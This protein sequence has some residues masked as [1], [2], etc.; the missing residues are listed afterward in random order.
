MGVLRAKNVG[1]DDEDGY[2]EEEEY[3]DEDEEETPGMSDEDREQLQTGTLKVKEGLFGSDVTVTDAQIQEALWHYYYDVG[4]SV[5]YLKNK[6]GT[7]LEEKAVTTPKKQ[8]TPSR[9]DQVV[10]AIPATPKS[11]TGRDPSF[12][13]LYL[14]ESS[15]CTAPR[16]NMYI[17]HLVYPLADLT[18]YMPAS[19]SPGFFWDT[20]WFGVPSHRLGEI[21]IEP[22]L[23][24]GRLLGGSSKPSKLAALAAA[25]KKKQ[26]DAKNATPA[27]NVETDKAVTL[28]DKLTLKSRENGPQTPRGASSEE[29]PAP[30]KY[31]RKRSPSPIQVPKR[32]A[33]PPPEPAKPLITFPDL[34]AQPSA[35]AAVLCGLDSPCHES[36]ETVNS[37]PL[38]YTALPDF[39]DA[40]PF[41]GPSPDDILSVTIGP[42]PKPARRT[43]DGHDLTTSMEKTVIEE[44]TKVRSKNLNVVVEF[45]RS[46]LK[47]MANFVVIGHVDHGKSTLMGRLLF[48]M[49]VISQRSIDK[50]RKEAE[51]MGKS[52]F[53]LAW[54]MDQ[55]SEERS[56]GVTVDIATD[57]F[58]TDTTQFTILDAPGH[59][60]FIPN[61]IA[62]ASQADFAVL[63]IDAST[64]SFESGLKGQTRE[65]AM[66]V[67]SMGVLRII[68]AVNKMDTVA[69]SQHRFEEI[70]RQMLAFLT[71]ASFSPKRITFV[72]CAGLTGEN[73]TRKADD[74]NAKWYTGE[75]LIEALDASEL[76]KRDLEKPFRLTIGDVFRGG[77]TTPVSISGRI[78]VGTVQVGDNILCM[79][80][81]ETATVKGIEVKDCPVDWAVAGQISTLHLVDIDPVHLRLGD[82]VTPISSPIKLYKSF[83]AKLLAFDHV[84]PSPVDVYRGRLQAEGTVVRL[85]ALLN[86]F[87]GE[88]VKKHPRIV[89]PGEVARVRVRLEREL[90]LEVG[91]RV[92][93]RFRGETVGA[94][95]VEG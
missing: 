67:R 91:G 9:F 75:T 43:S 39:K 80:A 27:T 16:L 81:R 61:M 65:H 12:L 52:S 22:R 18:N 69:W 66:I 31:L 47:R 63:V 25:R 95:V 20:P 87:S 76:P 60:D 84:I 32:V 85:D 23:P 38:P 29:T 3:Y 6:Y 62:G 55:T 17:G 78:D 41:A 86:R 92:V 26:E 64:N 10:E 7:A 46:G 34:R 42:K 44:S 19:P 82:V 83:S 70:S 59:R 8:K 49:N 72:P 30:R 50:L 51:T 33:S 21:T 14:Q 13:P 15:P 73:V 77:I 71:S 35:F 45:N 90:P 5:A 56:R 94:G 58:E 2:G 89:K 93:L 1:Y 4:K 48:D 36:P 54:V 79:P 28:L 24:R 88:V 53:A 74:P 11:A 40:N 37:F 57:Y 68:V